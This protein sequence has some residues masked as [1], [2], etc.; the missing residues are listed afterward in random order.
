M[1]ILKKLRNSLNLTQK[2]FAKKLSIEQ[3]TLSQYEADFYPSFKVI[4][5]ISEIFEVSIDYLLLEDK[6]FYPKSLSFIKKAIEL[7]HQNNTDSKS[8][9]K[10]AISNLIPEINNKNIIIKQDSII[11]KLENNFHDNLK[12]LRNINE[13]TQ[14]QIAEK[15]KIVRSV[16][17]LYET[18][19]YPS[20][21]KMIKLSQLF[22]CSIHTLVTGE[23]LSF[24]F[25]DKNFGKTI[26]IAD[27]LL[28]IEDKNFLIKLMGNILEK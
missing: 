22:N 21:D 25:K 17:S 15:L 1:K 19:N 8:F 12:I 26:F 6:C 24:D 4:K 16:V 7:N 27:H 9:V 13:L 28:S 3:N 2:E 20:I 18:K 11:E 5:K 23:K 14:N 10:K